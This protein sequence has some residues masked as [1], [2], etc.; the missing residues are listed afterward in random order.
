MHVI[1]LF[2]ISVAMEGWWCHQRV[3]LFSSWVDGLIN[4]DW[5]I[6]SRGLGNASAVIILNLRYLKWV[7][8][9]H[10]RRK[11][12]WYNCT[13][14]NQWWTNDDYVEPKVTCI[15]S[16]FT[17]C[18]LLIN[19]LWCHV[20]GQL[21]IGLGGCHWAEL[22]EVCFV[23]GVMHPYIWGLNRDRY[24]CKGCLIL[25]LILILMLMFWFWC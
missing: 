15:L 3:P 8:H 24:V 14:I 21:P 11:H 2:I 23:M 18:L 13:Q 25:I 9:E 10:P 7:F 19:L 16:L 20:G 22:V 4:S 1:W 6:N 12:L 5:H 17:L